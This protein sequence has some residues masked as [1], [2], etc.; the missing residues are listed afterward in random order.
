MV[1][2]LRERESDAGLGIT[3]NPAAKLTYD[4]PAVQTYT[5]STG[6]DAPASVS[7]YSNMAPQGSQATYA[8][9]ARAWV[10][11]QPAPPQAVAA[12]PAPPP[13]PPQGGRTWYNNLGAGQ[14]QQTADQWL[15][16]DSDY[17]AQ[18]GEYDRAL[19]DFISRITAQKAGFDTD[20]SQ[21]LGATDKNEQYS[22]NAL[23]EDFGA[24][25]M[26]YSGLFDKSKNE[27]GQRFQ[28]QRG[29]INNVRDKN[30]S[31]AD[32]RQAD[33]QSEN[34]IS[35]GNAKRSALTRMA[36]QQAMIDQN[37]GF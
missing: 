30:K 20:A 5:P 21:A 7:S 26:S 31:D 2:P 19:N 6:W 14:Q 8:P 18:M 24:R 22:T 12:P 4:A 32:N 25:G 1:R 9:A 11:P 37:A 13:A 15:G 16:G 35:R 23:G 17:T 27:L 36:A 34:N 28:E 29:N 33:Y 10:N 3:A